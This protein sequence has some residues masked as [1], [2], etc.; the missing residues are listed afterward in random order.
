MIKMFVYKNFIPDRLKKIIKR[1]VTV[2]AHLRIQLALVKRAGGS[3]FTLFNDTE[4]YAT[5]RTAMAR[6]VAS[7]RVA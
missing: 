6:R 7:H 3:D 4:P 5:I 1:Y 2:H